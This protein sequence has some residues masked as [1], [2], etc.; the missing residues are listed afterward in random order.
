MAEFAAGLPPADPSLTGPSLE[1]IILGSERFDP[2]NIEEF[3]E[4]FGVK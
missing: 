4:E 3:V 1:D 2:R